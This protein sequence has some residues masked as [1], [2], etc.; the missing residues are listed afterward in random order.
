MAE[1][2]SACAGTRMPSPASASGTSTDA[3]A[4]GTS[5]PSGLSLMPRTRTLRVAASIPGSTAITRPSKSRPRPAT[6]N[7]KGW[8]TVTAPA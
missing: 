4:P 3:N 2:T 1:G 5:A 6:W 7:V 8:P